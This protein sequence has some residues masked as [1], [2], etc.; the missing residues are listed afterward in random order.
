MTPLAYFSSWQAAAK[1]TGANPAIPY[2]NANIFCP[3]IT[4]ATLARRYGVGYVLEPAGAPGPTGAVFDRMVGNEQ[5]FRIP[6]A[7]I[8]TLV[9]IDPGGALPNPDTPGAAVGVANP[10]PAAWT[11][12]TDATSPQVLR[13]RLT[14]VPGWH[15]SIDGKPL[16]LTTFEGIMLQARVPPGRHIIELHYWPSTFTAGIVIALLSVLGLC[17]ALIAALISRGRPGNRWGSGE[18][19]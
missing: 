3:A 4:S 11:M 13:L 1:E 16:R 8:A 14:D 17:A 7:A 19:Q 9:P 5:L 10:N 2:R 12:H 6:G 15:A 18:P